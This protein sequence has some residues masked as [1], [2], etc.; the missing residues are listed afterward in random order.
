MINELALKSGGK[1]DVHLLV[2]VKNKRLPIWADER[3][4]NETLRNAVPREFW[5]ISTLWCEQQM[6]MYYP[7]PFSENFANF[8]GSTVHGVHRSP[9]FALQRFSQEHPEYDFIWNWEMDVRYTG[10]YYEFN[11]KIGGWAKRQP[12]KGLWERNRRFL[13]PEYHGDYQNF[14][15][16]VENETREVDVLK[17]NLTQSGPV[18]VWGPVQDFENSNLVPLSNET[19]PPTTY[20]EDDYQWGVGE[21]ADLLVF[22]PIFDPSQTNW[23]F[24]EDVTDYSRSQPIPPRRAAIVTA[25]R[26]SKRLLSIMHEEVWRQGH[27]MFP[28][29]FAP[30][31]CLH[32]GFKAVYV[33]HP[34]HFDRDWDLEYMDQVL[35]YPQTKQD[36]PF[37]WGEHNLQGSTFYYR[38]YFAESLWRR[39]LGQEVDGVGGQGQEEMGTGRMCLRSMLLHPVKRETEFAE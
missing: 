27:T 10:H 37:G 2:N 17:N 36:S 22:N 38:S 23:V 39:W 6:A 16:S 7:G 8:A 34:V 9:H 25:S 33:P 20:D 12:R 35:N 11:T 28:E 15:R 3:V 26:L 18:P 24:L 32:R 31:V 13:I 1:Y 5:N 4:Y 19:Q 21:E 29:M 30:S 14:T